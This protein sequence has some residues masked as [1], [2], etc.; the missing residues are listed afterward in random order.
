M[1]GLEVGIVGLLILLGNVYAII[2]IFGSSA[3][4][5]A[6]AVWIVLILILPIV[7][8]IIWFL[9]GPK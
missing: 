2:K 7:G 6:K 5:G 1:F 8:L 3:S 4:A 9:F